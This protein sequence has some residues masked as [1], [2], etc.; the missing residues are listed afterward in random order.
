M[1]WHRWLSVPCRWRT[2]RIS[3]HRKV[4]PSPH[5]PPLRTSTPS[6]FSLALAEAVLFLEAEGP[7]GS[8]KRLVGVGAGTR[9][10]L[11]A[12]APFSSALSFESCPQSR[13]CVWL[14][15]LEGGQG[16]SPAWRAFLARD[17]LSTPRGAERKRLLSGTWALLGCGVSPGSYPCNN[18]GHRDEADGGEEGLLHPLPLP[19]DGLL[20]GRLPLA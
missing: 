18:E 4:S 8:E 12:Q 10:V 1:P 2:Q 3:C 20:A 11:L 5:P 14:W 19:R 16:Q 9:E 15:P 17:V 6:L 7:R 13:L